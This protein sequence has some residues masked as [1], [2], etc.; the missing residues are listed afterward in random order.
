MDP[1]M[2]CENRITYRVQEGDSLYQLAKKFKTTVTELILLNAGMNPYNLKVGMK[3]IICPG[4]GYEEDKKPEKPGAGNIST[5]GSSLKEQMRMAWLNHIIFLKMGLTAFLENLASQNAWKNAVKQNADT[6]LDLFR[7]RYPESIMRRLELLMSDHI[8]LT[9]EVAA[10]L[11]KDPTA[12]TETMQDWYINA[13]E[14]ASLLSR[15]TPAYEE[16][17]L[18]KMLYQHLDA[19]RQQTEAY[20]DGD[21]ETDIRIF[22]QSEKQILE[23]ADFLT[24]GLMAR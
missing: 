2:Y 7:E 20:L 16:E 3:L 10:E 8:R 22:M 5:A 9:Y 19:V 15:Q 24:A 12:T 23:L 17:E 18:R 13:E 4:E 11:K 21:Y 1:K 14:M 6:I